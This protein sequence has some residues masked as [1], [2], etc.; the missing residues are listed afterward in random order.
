MAQ[1]EIKPEMIDSVLADIIEVAEQMRLNDLQHTAQARAAE[2]ET[3]KHEK[4]ALE[5]ELGAEHP[6]VRALESAIVGAE[7]VGKFASVTRN[8]AEYRTDVKAKK[9]C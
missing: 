2:V 1:K 9:T 8:H 4:E 5:K 6:R 3:F 7:H